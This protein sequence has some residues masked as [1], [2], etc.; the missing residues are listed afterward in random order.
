MSLHSQDWMKIITGLGLV[1]AGALTGGAAFGAAGAGAGAAGAGAGAGAGAAGGAALG[2]GAGA[3]AGG[4]AASA[5]LFGAAT[6]MISGLLASQ[7]ADLAAS[8]GARKYEDRPI[9][10]PPQMEGMDFNALLSQGRE[11]GSK[12]PMKRLSLG[13]Y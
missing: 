10:Q 6:P 4:T 12:L 13:G 2:A 1:A 5:G 9:G 7:G 8:G 11:H 3:A